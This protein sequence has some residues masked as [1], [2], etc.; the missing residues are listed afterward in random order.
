MSDIAQMNASLGL[1]TSD[2]QA[3]MD[4]AARTFEKTAESMRRKM[5]MEMRQMRSSVQRDADAMGQTFNSLASALK[6]GL[7]AG[8]AALGVDSVGNVLQMADK[9]NTLEQ[10]IKTA[11]K[12]TGDF[13]Q[14]NQQLFQIAQKNGAAFA[15]TVGVFQSL[16][17]ASKELGATNK[18]MLQLTDTVQK[19]GVIG[20]STSEQLKNGLLQFSQMMAGGTAHAE[21]MNSLLEN[22]PEIANRIARGL[23]LS[24]GQMR[25]LV[26]EGKITSKEVFESLQ[27]QAKEIA[28]EFDRMPITMARAKQTLDNAAEK[29]VGDL[30]HA[31]G[32]T[33]SIATAMNEV[34]KAMGKASE[35]AGSWFG[36][37]V[38]SGNIEG[39]RQDLIG[40]TWAQFAETFAT[41]GG[42]GGPLTFQGLG[43]GFTPDKFLKG[44]QQKFGGLSAVSQGKEDLEWF[45]NLVNPTTDPKIDPNKTLKQT[46]GP[47]FESMLAKE[48]EITKEYELRSE[49]KKV[50]AEIS[51]SIF[52]FESEL[53]IKLTEQQKELIKNAVTSRE[54]YKQVIE[55]EKKAAAEAKKRAEEQARIQEHFEEQVKLLDAQI[56]AEKK[57]GSI[58]EYQANLL[59]KRAAYEKS[60]TKEND[61]QKRILMEKFDLLAKTQEEND[62]QKRVKGLQ[63]ETKYIQMQGTALEEQIP[64]EKQ[65]DEL[66][67]QGR[68]TEERKLELQRAF[69]DKLAAEADLRSRQ[70]LKALKEQTDEMALQEQTQRLLDAGYYQQAEYMK[71]I[72]DFQKNV[73]R[74]ATDQEKAQISQNTNQREWLRQA[75][76]AREL[77]N[78][79]QTAQQKWN[80]QAQ[81]LRSYY[82]NGFI[83]LDQYRQAVV[84]L[85]PEFEK[86]RNMA[87]DVGDALSKGLDDWLTKGK[88]FTDVLKDIGKEL[89]SSAI[90]NLLVNPLQQGISNLGQN[91]LGK[92]VGAPGGTG[93]GGGLL[94]L[95]R[96]P[97]GSGLVQNPFYTPTQGIGAVPNRAVGDPSKLLSALDPSEAAGMI[98]ALKQAGYGAQG[99]KMPTTIGEYNQ[100][101]DALHQLLAQRYPMLS[102]ASGGGLGPIASGPNGLMTGGL[103]TLSSTYGSAPGGAVPVWI[104]GGASMG[105]P[106]MVP[107]TGMLGAM[108]NAGAFGGGGYGGALG[109]RAG[110]GGAIAGGGGGGRSD[111]MTGQRFAGMTKGMQEQWLADTARQHANDIFSNPGSTPLEK[112]I[113]AVQYNGSG[114]WSPYQQF[115]GKGQSW[116]GG[117]GGGFLVGGVSN[118]EPTAQEQNIARERAAQ[119]SRWAAENPQHLSGAGGN[120]KGGSLQYMGGLNAATGYGGGAGGLQGWGVYPGRN[121]IGW[122]VGGAGSGGLSLKDVGG[123]WGTLGNNMS[124]SQAELEEL[125]RQVAS[126]YQGAPGLDPNYV[127]ETSGKIMEGWSAKLQ[128]ARNDFFGQFSNGIL[129]DLE[130]AMRRIGSWGSGVWNNGLFAKQPNLGILKSGGGWDSQLTSATGYGGVFM[131]PQFSGRGYADGGRPPLNQVSLVGENGPE[132]WV[133]DTAGTVVPLSGGGSSST[134]GSSTGGGSASVNL[135]V[136]NHNAPPSRTEQRM[137]PNGPEL[138]QYFEEYMTTGPGRKMMLQHYGLKGKARA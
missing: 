126:Q 41:N 92:F 120:S 69:N 37:K 40:A 75:G 125:R 86:F 128:K 64:L 111:E 104:V 57:R 97:S 26:K 135:S 18:D 29:F 76:Q 52:K 80:K 24:V 21:E 15:D 6:G 38:K 34:A 119:N 8:L 44:V 60:I 91:L 20:G 82:E 47:T 113:A 61:D 112:S 87:K 11:T 84:K 5:E 123:A 43:A 62:Y 77:I 13:A 107:M 83:S 93:G 16:A 50:D 89:A 71:E 106:G 121:G 99:E 79:L 108:N 131:M 23:G 109:G 98:G 134:S 132:L 129:Q 138:H 127:P 22:T 130:T 96:A 74:E 53:K 54:H 118:D 45:N 49:K 94:N 90:K 51:E 133:P 78:S 4:R 31:L 27:K 88:K 39:S 136:V 36:G 59:E 124:G 122:G 17:R 46:K 65:L 2:F 56:E 48:R 70:Q 42:K 100:I 32:I 116:G 7:I 55:D 28:E 81:D 72:Y 85:N 102:R 95:L 3:G 68:L 110:G 73:K 67:Q 25:E 10:R 9:F 101:V 1:K 30:D 63:E 117:G 33:T 12:A 14:V 66:R 35:A 105:S 58:G 19:L 137:G 114:V 103:S 115:V